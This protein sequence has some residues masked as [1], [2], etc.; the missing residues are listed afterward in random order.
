MARTSSPAAAHVGAIIKEPRLKRG[1]SQDDLASKTKIDRSAGME[2]DEAG[3]VNG[4]PIRVPTDDEYRTCSVCGGDC[5][6]D[7]GSGSDGLGAR[8][9]FVCPEHGVQSLVNRSKDC[10]RPTAVIVMA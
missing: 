5:E 7:I 2:Y 3:G 9:A 10:G 1:M 8:I 6:P 4:V